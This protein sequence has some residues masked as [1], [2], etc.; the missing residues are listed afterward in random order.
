MRLGND[1]LLLLL[2]KGVIL[3]ILLDIDHFILL[4]TR[5]LFCYIFFS[6]KTFSKIFRT[7][8]DTSIFYLIKCNTKLLKGALCEFY[9]KIRIFHEF[10]KG[11][12]KK[13]ENHCVIRK[14]VV[15]NSKVTFVW[16]TP[17]KTHDFYLAKWTGLNPIKTGV[18]FSKL[19]MQ[20]S[21]CPATYGADSPQVIPMRRTCSLPWQTCAK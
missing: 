16:A 5:L 13:V 12:Y 19:F 20:W 17:S 1:F 18:N 9:V 3:T 7:G 2:H 11:I 21:N 14:K 4:R 15:W 10:T 8:Y 6:S